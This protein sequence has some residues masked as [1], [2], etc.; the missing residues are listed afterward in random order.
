[1]VDSESKKNLNSLEKLNNRDYLNVAINLCAHLIVGL[2]LGLFLDKYFTTKPMFLVLCLII[3]IISA[4][5]MILN[6]K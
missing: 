5:K 1:M 3:G 6:I 2:V 4:I